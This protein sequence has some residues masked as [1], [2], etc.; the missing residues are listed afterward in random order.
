MFWGMGPEQL[1]R[2]YADATNADIRSRLPAYILI[3]AVVA[4]VLALAVLNR[5]PPHGQPSTS[6]ASTTLTDAD[7]RARIPLDNFKH[8]SVSPDPPDPRYPLMMRLLDEVSSALPCNLSGFVT[9]TKWSHYVI[10][11]APLN[12]HTEDVAAAIISGDPQARSTPDFTVS[13]MAG[14]Q[15]LVAAEAE[16]QRLPLMKCA[17]YGIRRDGSLWVIHDDNFNCPPPPGH[18]PGN[19]GGVC[20]G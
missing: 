11:L 16:V 18:C 4:L 15:S 14:K 7:C 12:A 2:G 17:R 3:L 5:H 9:E 1:E 20:G 19:D 6:S 8:N 10:F 13:L